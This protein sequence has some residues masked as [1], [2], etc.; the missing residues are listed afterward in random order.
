MFLILIKIHETYHILIIFSPDISTK[1]SFNR[2]FKLFTQYASS[3][4][5]FVYEH[6]IKT[7]SYFII[8]KISFT[9]ILDTFDF[10]IIVTCIIIWI[11]NMFYAHTYCS[12]IIH[13]FT[14]FIL[15]N[16]HINNFFNMWTISMYRICNTCSY[17]V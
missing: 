6:R 9:L 15:F 4:I 1:R 14:I 16:A 2:F 12:S 3:Y 17:T 5:R 10:L 7:F 11:F 13:M 8:K